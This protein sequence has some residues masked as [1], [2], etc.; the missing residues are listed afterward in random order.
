MAENVEENTGPSLVLPPPFIGWRL[1]GICREQEGVDG[2]LPCHGVCSVA[3]SVAWTGAGKCIWSIPYLCLQPGHMT[4]ARVL[5][6]QFIW[7][8]SK[9]CGVT[10]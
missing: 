2:Q 6:E 8:S 3:N 4:A 9:P 10:I 7:K 1:Q 5:Q